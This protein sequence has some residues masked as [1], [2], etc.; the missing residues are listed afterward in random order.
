M[1]LGAASVCSAQGGPVLEKVWVAPEVNYGDLLKVY[2]KAS[3][4][5]GDMRFVIVSGG[6]GAV[7]SAVTRISKK[8]RKD[9]NGYLWWDT[10]KAINRDTTGAVSIQIEDMKGA[11]SEVMTVP[12]KIVSRGAKSQ[13]P[14]PE[15]QEV[16]IGPIM[17]EALRTP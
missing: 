11:E 4:P 5:T 3:D 7:G 8:A 12:V 17:I 16:E 1:V 14:P 9:L 6:R 10:T 13:S 2:V 15:F